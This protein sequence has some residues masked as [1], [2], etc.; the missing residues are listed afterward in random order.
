MP[1]GVPSRTIT[2]L[3]TD[4]EE[5]TR[6]LREV[7]EGYAELLAEHR[8]AL[9]EA[10]A[11]HRGREVDTQGDA[12]FYVFDSVHVVLGEDE[13]AG[14]ATRNLGEHRL[15][16]FD[17]PERLYQLLIDGLPSDLRPLRTGARQELGHPGFADAE[18]RLA[19]VAEATTTQAA[20]RPTGV[21]HALH[22]WARSVPGAAAA[23]LRS[24]L[25]LS[26]LALLVL[27][28]VFYTPWSLAAAAG[29]V[30][31][32]VALKAGS[33]RRAAV[34]SMGLRVYALRA[35]APHEDLADRVKQLGAMLVRAGMVRSGPTSSPSG[36]GTCRGRRSRRTSCP[37]TP[38]SR[39]P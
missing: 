30:L 9:R 20:P 24:P 1:V 37:W 28:G 27:P 13:V 8:R 14:T 15:K 6:L 3:F 7:G 4:I 29:V 19:E 32:M 38:T 10:F 23:V 31:A 11:L 21:G 5:S 18:G 33:H 34:D 17:Q 35:L 39:T 12:S 22:H 2:L 36:A 26:V 16:D 25:D